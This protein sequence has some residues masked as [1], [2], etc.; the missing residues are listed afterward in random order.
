MPH[1][2]E[3][4]KYH[5]LAVHEK[6]NVSV[7]YFSGTRESCWRLLFCFQFHPRLLLQLWRGKCYTDRDMIRPVNV[8][9]TVVDVGWSARSARAYWLVG[10]KSTL[11]YK[12][13]NKTYTFGMYCGRST[14]Y[15]QNDVGLRNTQTG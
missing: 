3:V 14:K 6:M 13:E 2:V 5:V 10:K 4:M 1:I 15:L 9:Y 12:L 8:S 11:L 7:S